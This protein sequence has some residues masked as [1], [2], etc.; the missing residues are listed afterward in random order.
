MKENN[1]VF[2][3]KKKTLLIAIAVLVVMVL[4]IKFIPGNMGNDN[5]KDDL[6][7]NTFDVII[8]N[9]QRCKECAQVSSIVSQLEGLFPD[10]S[11]GEIDYMSEE[12]KKL[13]EETNVKFL[14]AILFNNDSIKQ[15]ENYS[16]VKNYLE[17]KGDFVSLKIGSNFDPT[18]EICDNEIDDNGNGK[19]DCEDESCKTNPACMETICDDGIDDE[20][21]GLVDCDD[22]DCEKNWQCMMPKKDKPE[23]ELFV[24]SHCPYGTQIEKG[25]LSVARLLGDKID[26]NINFCSYAMHGKKELDEEILQHCIQKDYNNKYLDYLA[27][28]LK[29]GNTDDC[30]KEIELSG[31]LDKCI[32]ETD[33]KFKITEKFNDQSTWSGGRYPLFDVYKESNDKYGVSGS[34]TLV[35]NGVIAEKVKRDSAS[36]LDAICIGFID[37]PSECSE[38]LSSENPSAGFGF[39]ATSSASSGSCG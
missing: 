26:F 9:D 23:V 19:I 2:K 37:K 3:I 21:D 27:C 20:G 35:I 11:F 17:Q 36:L 13:Y 31:K 7:S 6:S 10:L 1:F 16:Q 29:E 15:E 25:I 12:G 5:S 22:P 14:P 8:L 4:V 38:K 24:M 33:A 30:L 28:F 32:A 34:P 39:S 18:G